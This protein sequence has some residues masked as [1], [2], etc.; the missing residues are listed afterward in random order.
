MTTRK[1]TVV[2]LDFFAFGTLSAA[3][4]KWKIVVPDSGVVKAFGGYVVT[5]GTGTTAIQIR[6]ATTSPDK[7]LFQVAPTIDTTTKLLTGGTMID[8]P[9]V[10]A[11][12][13]L[14]LDVD[15]IATGAANL[16]VWLVVEL[17]GVV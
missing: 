16:H 4:N 7:D 3:N 8:S 13:V 15:S 6:N 2:Y 10:S 17:T 5:P 9:T 12:D 14:C 1:V 11:S